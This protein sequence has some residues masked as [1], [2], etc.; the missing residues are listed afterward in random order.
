MREGGQILAALLN[1]LRHHVRAGQTGIEIN[2]WIDARIRSY[3]AIPTYRDPSVNFPGS[4]CIS[5]NEELVH[6]IPKPYAF[7]QG[8]KV[9]F[10]LTITYRNMCV[11]SAFTM[12]VDEE[13]KGAIKHLLTTTEN[14]LLE[15]IATV[16]PGSTTG[17][18]GAAVERTLTRGK[19]GIIR[20]YV[21][22]GIGDRM[23]MPPD[24]PNFG[25]P[26]TGHTLQIGD[27]ICIEPMA[28]LGKPKT[29]VLEDG[30]TVATVDQSI[31]AH[32]EHTVLV[33]PTGHEILTILNS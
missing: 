1:E 14:S 32:F 22:H 8:D 5:V 27:T 11:D 24:I 31:C 26:G 10:D 23:H 28:V 18:I 2:T 20:D 12:I 13:P 21:G 16:R 25:R 9:S 15:G 33:T 7:E 29:H 6:S 4:I 17:D 19:L 3:G 30:W